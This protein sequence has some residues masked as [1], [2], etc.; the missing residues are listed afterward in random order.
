MLTGIKANPKALA[1]SAA[2]VK[3][4]QY[5]AFKNALNF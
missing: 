2:S 5:L 4:K 1:T 3:A